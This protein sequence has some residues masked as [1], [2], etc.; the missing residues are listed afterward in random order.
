ML[1]IRPSTEL[2]LKPEVVSTVYKFITTDHDPNIDNSDAW[3]KILSDEYNNRVLP[4]DITI[5]SVI[6]LAHKYCDNC[7]DDKKESIIQ[8]VETLSVY[9][10]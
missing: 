1:W 7:S 8:F 6:N 2:I 4:E 3:L 9:E 10:E 5:N